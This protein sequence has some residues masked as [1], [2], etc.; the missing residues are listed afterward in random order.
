[1]VTGLSSFDKKTE[2]HDDW[3]HLPRVTQLI[4]LRHLNL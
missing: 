3:S 4:E 1:M 2:A